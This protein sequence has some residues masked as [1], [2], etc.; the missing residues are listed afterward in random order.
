MTLIK[1]K[2]KIQRNSTKKKVTALKFGMA[3]ALNRYYV[4]LRRNS[5]ETA[6]IAKLFL[7]GNGGFANFSS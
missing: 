3:V 5:G 7:A 4:E 1:T 2:T 6:A